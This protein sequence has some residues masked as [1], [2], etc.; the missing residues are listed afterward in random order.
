MSFSA[1]RLNSNLSVTA[2]KIP[3]SEPDGKLKH[4]VKYTMKYNRMIL[5]PEAS[6]KRFKGVMYK[7]NAE[8]DT[9]LAFSVLLGYL[10]QPPLLF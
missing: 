9:S 7:V 5:S 10:L 1:S 8:M 4:F 2:K 6:R 3:Y